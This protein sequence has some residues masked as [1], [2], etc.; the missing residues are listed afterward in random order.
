MT[1]LRSLSGP[2][3]ASAGNR[4]IVPDCSG[5]GIVRFAEIPP[6]GDLRKS[7]D[8]D[9][10]WVRGTGAAPAQ[11]SPNGASGGAGRGVR[12]RA[13]RRGRGGASKGNAGH[14]GGHEALPWPSP[15]RATL[16]ARISLPAFGVVHQSS[17]PLTPPS[18]GL[19]TSVDMTC[20]D[21]PGWLGRAKT[22]VSRGGIGAVF[23]EGGGWKRWRHDYTGLML[24]C[25]QGTSTI[26]LIFDNMDAIADLCREFRIRSLDVFGSAA[27]E[28]FDPETSDIDLICDLGEYEPGVA[29]RFMAFADALEALFGRKVDLLTE[30]QIQNPY[31]RYAVNKSRVKLHEAGDRHAAA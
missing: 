16:G 14:G 18:R 23:R 13:I 24:P 2:V 25:H 19:E 1:C 10:V 30:P 28:A 20:R 29:H 12:R 26:S 9:R 5:R 31:F 27:T 22:I 21:G 15:T 11:D 6:S 17:S 4:A 8:A 3:L 7:D